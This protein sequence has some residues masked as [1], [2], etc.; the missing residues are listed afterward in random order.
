[1]LLFTAGDDG[2]VGV[3]DCAALRAMAN[4]SIPTAMVQVITEGVPRARR[5]RDRTHGAPFLPPMGTS[6]EPV[7]LQARIGMT[8]AG[9]SP[10]DD[11]VPRS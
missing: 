5:D 11:R 9:T 8:F 6:G 3:H 7:A 1:M 10:T 4:R 2:H